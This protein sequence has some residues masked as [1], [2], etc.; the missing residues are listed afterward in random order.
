MACLMN[1]QLLQLALTLEGEA[2]WIC[3]EYRCP[4]TSSRRCFFRVSSNTHGLVFVLLCHLSVSEE[5]L[6]FCLFF[7]SE[8]QPYFP[9]VRGALFLLV[10]LLD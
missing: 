1:L 10:L 8:Y 6:D 7:L 4:L 2:A 3:D 5:Q 9:A